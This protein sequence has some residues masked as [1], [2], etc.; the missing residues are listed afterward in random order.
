M[1]TLWAR[2]LASE[3]ETPGSYSK[4]ALELLSVLEKQEAHLFTSACRFVVRINGE[5]TPAIFAEPFGDR[6]LT[7][8]ILD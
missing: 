8:E 4:R 3:A 2:V 5:S 6:H 1:Q 7:T